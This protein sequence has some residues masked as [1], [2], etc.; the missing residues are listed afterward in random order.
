MLK[1]I[2]RLEKEQ[3]AQLTKQLIRNKILFK[4]KIQKEEDRN[5]KSRIIKEKLF[6]IRVFQKAKTVMFY[7][8]LNDEVDTRE[9]IKEAQNLGKNILVPVCWNRTIIACM[10]DNHAKLQKGPYGVWE[11]VIKKHVG[12]DDLG[13]VIVPGLAFDKKGNRLGRG[14]GYYDRFL[15]TVPKTT[16]S[17]GMAFDFQILPEVPVTAT[18]INVDQIIFA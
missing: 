6:R 16:A 10:L 17:I 4:L 1:E 2:N 14:K 15:T 5:R 8:P 11:P 3:D 18:D 13:A 7:I 12:L 9:M